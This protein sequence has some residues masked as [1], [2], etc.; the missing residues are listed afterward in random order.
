MAFMSTVPAAINALVA[1]ANGLGLVGTAVI[2]GPKVGNPN[3]QE[4]LTIGFQ[5]EQT[6]TV[7]EVEYGSEGM[8]VARERE[9]YNVNCA[10][11]VLRGSAKMPEARTRS[12]E[13]LAA[14]GAGLLADHT[15][16]GAVMSATIGSATLAEQQT[17]KGAIATVKFTVQIDAFTPA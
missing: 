17:P 14:F 4:A 10:A 5:D 8:A 15:L 11:M 2:D 13:I 6:E 12:Y 1:V 7:V 3:T 9:Q 16:G